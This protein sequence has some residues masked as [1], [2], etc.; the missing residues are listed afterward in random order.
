MATSYTDLFSVGDRTNLI[1]VTSNITFSNS[2]QPKFLVDGLKENTYFPSGGVAGKY[3]TFD[4]KAPVI[5]D[6]AKFLTNTTSK[7]GVWRWQGSV[8]G[9]AWLNIGGEFELSGS[10]TGNILN[11]LNG[12]V[13]RYRFYRIIGVSGNFN[14]STVIYEFEFK[15]ELVMYNKSLVY[16]A[17]EYKTFRSG[18][19]V[20]VTTNDPTF[21]D[22]V[23]D[24]MDDIS[25][26]PETAWGQLTGDVELVYFTEESI[27]S[28]VQ[29]NI[30]TEPF[31]L[32]DEFAG[33]TIKII[34]YTDNLIQPESAVTLETEPFTLY[35]ELGDEVDVLY[36]TDDPDKT[37]A[38]LE[39]NAEYSPL[40]ELD[41][42]FDV[43][44]WTD[45][46]EVDELNISM[47]ALPFQQL[48][49]TPEEIGTY[50]DLKSFIIS[51]I[52][53]NGK[54]RMLFSFDNGSSWESCKFNS[55][56]LVNVQD[57]DD[58]RKNAMSTHDIEKL[59][60]KHFN[61]KG[62]HF[63]IA[64]FIEES[65]HINDPSIVDN[66][67]IITNSPVEDVKFADTAFYLLNTLATINVKVAGNKLSG[68]IDDADKGKVQYRVFLNGKPYYPQNGEFTNLAPSPLN[69]QLNISEREIIFGVENTLRV[70]F[71]DAWGQTDY[72]E[73]KFIGTYSGLMFMDENRQ[74]Y[75]DT[76]GG[77]LKY[78]D[79]DVIVAGQTTIDQKVIVKNQLGERLQ[80]LLLE[81]QEDK[82]PQ[83]VQ[84]QLSYTSSPFIPEKYL[85]FNKFIEIDEENTFYV[86]IATD[87]NAQPDPNGQFEIRATADTV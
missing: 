62:T 29:F 19:W 6:E 58:I 84:I 73:T 2:K 64:Y 87:I 49:I 74:Y 14:T 17:G 76:F 69:I 10:S 39:I 67:K 22:F 80:N 83:G 24:G 72:W 36:Y 45:N 44:T 78:L 13:E 71:Q 25:Q 47:D 85:L 65:Q 5:V 20:T 37:S 41:G 52:S 60:D 51:Q 56:S 21:D 38:E 1:E 57:A 77:V 48:L 43:V 54:L 23:S 63:K 9:S 26:I 35:D 33:Q 66:I 61:N 4:F 16:N 86:R 11:T 59:S 75:S 18:V 32:E 50:G 53:D 28:E 40:D 31:I 81:V 46:E 30:K 70:E 79:F 7:H 68:E 12:N 3:I 42:D 55:W 27:K 15:S 8:D 34:E 82:L